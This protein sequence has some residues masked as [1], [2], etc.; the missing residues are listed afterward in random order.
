[1]FTVGLEKVPCNSKP[2]SKAKPKI[3]PEDPLEDRVVTC[4]DVKLIMPTIL[5]LLFTILILVTV[6]PYAFINAINQLHAV[7]AAE[8]AG[9]DFIHLN[10][11]P[12]IIFRSQT[13]HNTD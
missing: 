12:N 8:D 10:T 11:S 7:Q 3:H 13:E 1:M 2:A 4:R 5:I 6:I 9:T